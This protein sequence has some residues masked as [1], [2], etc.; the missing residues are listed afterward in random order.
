MSYTHLIWPINTA[1]SHRALGLPWRH[2]GTFP[3]NDSHVTR[4]GSYIVFHN[5][6][7]AS[8]LRS[9][10]R[11]YENTRCTNS[12]S[13]ETQKQTAL[14]VKSSIATPNHVEAMHYLA[15]SLAHSADWKFGTQTARSESFPYRTPAQ[16]ST[17][18][19]QNRANAKPY[20]GSVVRNTRS[21]GP[22]SFSFVT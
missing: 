9:A 1:S 10:Q 6:S 4:L 19:W 21:Q 16:R 12:F 11:M 7:V 8:Q 14:G 20:L 3:V 13:C 22:D 2:A 5:N 18:N 15:T 17:A